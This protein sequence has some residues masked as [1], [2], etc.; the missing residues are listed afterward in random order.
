MDRPNYLVIFLVCL[1]IFVYAYF[2]NK[3]LQ[4]E[5]L[6]Q[7]QS[8]V[9]QEQQKL[10]LIHKYLIMHESQ[11]PIYLNNDPKKTYPKTQI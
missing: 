5:K 3:N 7:D 2:D 10:I 1:L 4:L 11:S 6:L 8:A 9:I